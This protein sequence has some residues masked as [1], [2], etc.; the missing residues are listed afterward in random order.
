MAGYNPPMPHLAF[1]TEIVAP[2]DAVWKFHDS[3]DALPKITPPGTRVHIPNPPARLEKGVQF[4]LIARQSPIPIPLHWEVRYADYEPPLRF[5]DEQVKGP[6][7]KWRHEHRFEALPNGN[8]LLRDTIE[9]EPP[10]WIFGKI[11]DALFIRRQLNAMFAYRH[12]ATKRALES[13]TL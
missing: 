3:L 1:V 4:T 5:V 11:A 6:F 2:Q 10:F 9:Y 12:T 7:A 8:T 13:P